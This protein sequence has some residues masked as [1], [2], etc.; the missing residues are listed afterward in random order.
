M[1]KERLPRGRVKFSQWKCL[2]PVVPGL[3]D[4]QCHR[5]HFSRFLSRLRTL[6]ETPLRFFRRLAGVPPCVE[7]QTKTFFPSLCQKLSAQTLLLGGRR[8][9]SKT[10]DFGAFRV[11]LQ[12]HCS[13]SFGEEL[14]MFFS[15]H[16]E[17]R[18]ELDVCLERHFALDSAS[19]DSPRTTRRSTLTVELLWRR[20][21]KVRV[22][23]GL[24]VYQE[25]TVALPKLL[26]KNKREVGRAFLYQGGVV[27]FYSDLSK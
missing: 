6:S 26:S 7:L 14:Q 13:V 17:P 1:V 20:R 8:R 25:A 2:L 12:R 22:T 27:V 3:R 18:N 23:S 21:H 15:L 24:D 5:S 11:F 19:T 9:F 10:A 4:F 16:R